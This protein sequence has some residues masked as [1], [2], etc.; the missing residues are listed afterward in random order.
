MSLQETMAKDRRRLILE[1]LAA[2]DGHGLGASV[3][4]TLVG[5]ARHRAYR[6]V[7]E[8]DITFLAQHNLVTLEELPSA[9]GPQ[10]M[11]TLTGLGLDVAGGRTHPVIA[12]K[13]P[14]Y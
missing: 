10:R 8:A 1:H 2:A 4:A 3:L 12:D 5:Q 13:L 14:T 7:V 9:I 6:D 11:V